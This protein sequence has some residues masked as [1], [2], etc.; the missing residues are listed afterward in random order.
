VVEF[1][2]HAVIKFKCKEGIEKTIAFLAA[3]SLL[4]LLL[5]WE[6]VGGWKGA[7]MQ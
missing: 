6:L 5:Q 7:M 2:K 4:Y 3:W 1:A